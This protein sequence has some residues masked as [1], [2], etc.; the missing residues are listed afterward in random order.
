MDRQIHAAQHS[1]IHEAPEQ[2]RAGLTVSPAESFARCRSP[3]R[4]DAIS[5]ACALSAFSS[6]SSDTLQ[7]LASTGAAQLRK[8]EFVRSSSR[9]ARFASFRSLGTVSLKLDASAHA[10]APT[11]LRP[12]QPHHARAAPATRRG[13]LGRVF[14]ADACQHR[15]VRPALAA[16]LTSQIRRRGLRHGQGHPRGPGRLVSVYSTLLPR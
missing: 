12:S 2:P 4:R 14:V 15:R 5:S 1:A 6:R 3:G 16:A 9:L 10:R 7:P 11:R 13:Q 8:R